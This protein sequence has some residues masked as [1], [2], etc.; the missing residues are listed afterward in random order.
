MHHPS[1]LSSDSLVNPIVRRNKNLLSVSKAEGGR[2]Q[3]GQSFKVNFQSF[4]PASN[5][6]T[7]RNRDRNFKRSR[8]KEV[9]L[10]IMHHIHM[11]YKLQSSNLYYTAKKALMTLTIVSSRSCPPLRVRSVP[12]RPA[13]S[14]YSPPLI[15]SAGHDMKGGGAAELFAAKVTN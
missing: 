2:P 9:A 12:I 4:C 6:S 13:A 10:E 11:Q 14:S 3:N 8:P 15:R 1:T 5:K 7:E